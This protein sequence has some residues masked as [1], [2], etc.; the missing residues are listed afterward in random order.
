MN[1]KKSG[2][3]TLE[4]RINSF[5]PVVHS[6]QKGG[7]MVRESLASNSRHYSYFVTGSNGLSTHWRET[8][9]GGMG[10]NT[11][12]SEKSKPVYLQV[13][14]EGSSFTTAYKY[15]KDAEWIPHDGPR[16]INF[17]ESESD[18][19]YVGIAVTS[20]NNGALATLDAADL[21]II[22]NVD[23]PEAVVQANAGVIEGEGGRR[24]RK[25]V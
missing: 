11:K 5:D 16:T 14:K 8:T 17:D 18:E 24:L 25:G 19:F 23:E 21:V 2:D 1:L 12:W 9:N 7:L 3:V 4:I 15:E 22:D 6:W 10:H 13:T 20:H